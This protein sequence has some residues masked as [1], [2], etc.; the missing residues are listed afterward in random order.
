MQ[1]VSLFPFCLSFI[2]LA[3]SLSVQNSHAN[4]G[5]DA[6]EAEGKTAYPNWWELQWNMRMGNV[7]AFCY[8]QP[9]LVSGQAHSPLLSGFQISQNS[10]AAEH[11]QFLLEYLG[12]VVPQIKLYF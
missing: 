8:S 9:G 7:P 6:T 4:S 12:L 3:E 1:S 10:M 5:T 2:S 11:A